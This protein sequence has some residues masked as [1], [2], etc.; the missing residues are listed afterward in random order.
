[1]TKA[2]EIE[3]DIICDFTCPWSYIGK[4]RLDATL[5]MFDVAVKKTWYPYMLAADLP[6]GGIPRKEW[7]AKT[8]G[9]PQQVEKALEPIKVAGLQDG[10]EFN[11]DAIDVQPNTI[12]AHRLM[13]WARD[14]GK[15]DALAE[16]LFQ[17][18]FLEG[19]DIGDHDVLARAAAE[20]GIMDAFKARKML[21]SDLDVDEVWKEMKEVHDFG[22]KHIPAFVFGRKYAIIGADD[23]ITMA[24]TIQGLLEEAESA[25]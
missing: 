2:Q 18:Y 19:E 3:I 11:F 1:M 23:P 20:L 24:K 4:K 14:A 17:L 7:L 25:N 9:P 8:Y 15:A 12:D 22:I 21:E 5:E 6:P 13:R 10:I 16:R